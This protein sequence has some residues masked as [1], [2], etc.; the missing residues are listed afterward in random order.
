MTKK[1]VV[2]IAA[3]FLIAGCSAPQATKNLSKLQL[4]E[5]RNTT[6]MIRELSQCDAELLKRMETHILNQVSLD[7]YIQQKGL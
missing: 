7:L 1:I 2:M 3:A 5:L 4:E 6:H